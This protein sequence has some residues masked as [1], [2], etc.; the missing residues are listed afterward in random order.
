MTWSMLSRDPGG[1]LVEALSTRGVR[2]S[3]YLVLVAALFPSG[4]FILALA[5]LV[6]LAVVWGREYRRNGSRKIHYLAA[7]VCVIVAA[8]LIAR[9]DVRNV[10]E[11][12]LARNPWGAGIE[13]VRDGTYIGQGDGYRGPIRVQVQVKDHRIA[14]VKT[15]EYPDLISVQD[16]ALAQYKSQ[17]IATGRLE[18]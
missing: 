17:I 3:I 12:R 18:P 2:L 1:V 6:G 10:D 16:N 14:G 13:L 15:L 5:L 8:F 7:A 11:L 9:V 4:R